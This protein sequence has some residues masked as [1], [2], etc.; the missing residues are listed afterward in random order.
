MSSWLTSFGSDFID[1]K[2]SLLVGHMQTMQTQIIFNTNEKYHP[3]TFKWKWTSQI[4][5][6]WK[7]GLNYKVSIYLLLNWWVC[8]YFDILITLT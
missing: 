5:K 3:A 8:L 6:S 4:Y 2:I 7:N 1:P